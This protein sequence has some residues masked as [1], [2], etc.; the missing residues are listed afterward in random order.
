MEAGPGT[1]HE[2]SLFLY[3]KS[4]SWTEILSEARPPVKKRKE[5]HKT[6]E[7]ELGKML[8]KSI[9]ASCKKNILA[10]AQ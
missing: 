5:V 1:Q 4:L 2:L 7:R 6:K 10:L 3:E 9:S 8:K